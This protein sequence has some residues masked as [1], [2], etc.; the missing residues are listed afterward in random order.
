MPNDFEAVSNLAE[1]PESVP[2]S[3]PESMPESMPEI[4]RYFLHVGCGLARP[5]RLP[6]CFRDTGWNEIRLDIDPSVQPHILASI[7]DMK[8]IADGWI[9]AIW[10]SHNLEHLN[11]YEVPLALKEFARVLKPEGFVLLNMPD[12]RAIARHILADNVSRPLYLSE[13]GAITP[14][15]MLFGHQRSLQNGHHYMA[16]RTGFTATTLAESLLE[17]GFAEVRVVEGSRWD[18]WAVASMSEIPE[19]LLEA[20]AA[21]TP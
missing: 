10:S 21:V 17:A 2:E 15:D 16:H 11:G 4:A 20:L 7:T 19:S 6:A 3:V 5:E 18:L 8:M 14:L 9:D 12:L 1:T 13:V